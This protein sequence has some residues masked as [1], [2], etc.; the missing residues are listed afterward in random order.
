MKIRTPLVEVKDQLI[1]FIAEGYEILGYG[2]QNYHDANGVPGKQ[3]DWE[4]RILRYFSKTFPTQKEAGQIRYA[5]YNNGLGYNDMHADVQKAVNRTASRIDILES[6]LEKLE[7]YYQFEPESL[8]LFVQNIASF[9]KVRG[10]NHSEVTPFLKNGFL[11][12]DEDS[13][14]RAFAEIIGES[15]CAQRLG[16]RKSRFI[17]L[18]DDARRAES[19]NLSY[20]QWA[21]KS[22]R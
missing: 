19:P 15:I 20:S 11:N 3:S 18:A 5:P 17:H 4:Q 1:N 6:L 13:I 9:V 10:V 21:W 12:K 22:T 7:A 2:Y 8:R 16:R 14:K